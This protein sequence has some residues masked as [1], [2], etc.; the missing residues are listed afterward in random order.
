[1][2]VVKTIA[3]RKY[4]GKLNNTKHFIY[5][6]L[7]RITREYNEQLGI[8]RTYIYLPNG[9]MYLFGTNR[10]V[11]DKYGRLSRFGNDT[12]YSYYHQGNR[13][14]RKK[15][16]QITEYSY[17]CGMLTGIDSNRYFY[18]VNGNR[19]AKQVNGKNTSYFY[20]G[21]KLVAEIKHDDND[22]IYYYFYD[23]DGITGINVDSRDY[24]YIKDS[25]GNVIMLMDGAKRMV[26]RYEYDMWGNCTI[27]NEA[28]EVETDTNSIGYLNPIRWKGFYFDQEFGLYYANGSYYDPEVGLYVDA[29]PI[30][31]VV[32]NA[33][34]VRSLDRN[35]IL[36]NNTI[37]MACS[38]Y[39]IATYVELSPDPSYDP[40]YSWQTKLRMWIGKQVNK[41]ID[42]YQQLILDLGLTEE[43]RKVIDI[44][45]CVTVLAVSIV[46]ACTVPGGAALIVG[47]IIG[48]AL[49]A[50]LSILSQGIS[51]G[52]DKINWLQVLFDAGLGIIGGMLAGSTIS[53]ITSMVSGGVIAG[54]N[55]IG[56]DVMTSGSIDFIKA[57]FM[58]GV[59]TVMGKR[60]GHG[61]KNVHEMNI[62]INSG[63]SWG[64]KHFFF[65]REKL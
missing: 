29:A 36:C 59:G 63:S 50:G 17:S 37:E 30:S 3:I 43:Q 46:I 64:R 41:A 28:N 2:R 14:G 21:S 60:S 7:H 44:V 61:A 57:G 6:N 20:D 38:P 25:F 8:D 51:Q 31:T 54:A 42:K 9:R 48:G 55:S 33:C 1:M 23:K 40:K 58:I 5:D 32:D 56:D 26:A 34:S 52:W 12:Y 4:K 13:Q 39:T 11:Y 35:S 18:D 22:K 45:L 15:N 65:I 53:A 62:R 24:L 47:G 19:Y 10:C 49:G 27:Y 16:G